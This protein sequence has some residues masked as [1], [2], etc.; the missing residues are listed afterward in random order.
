MASNLRTSSSP[1][2]TRNVW[3]LIRNIV[4]DYGADPTGVVSCVS[5]FYTDFKTEAA[6]KRAL[7]TIPDG[8][9]MNFAAFGGVSWLSLIHI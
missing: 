8:S 7:L 1:S 5:D 6:G 2:G 4:T 9:I 3:D